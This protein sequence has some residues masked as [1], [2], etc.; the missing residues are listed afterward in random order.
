MK[1]IFIVMGVFCLAIT[2]I[3]AKGFEVSANGGLDFGKFETGLVLGLTGGTPL[4]GNILGEVEF[5]YYF[6]TVEDPG[7]PGMDFSGSAWNLNASALYTFK[8]DKSKIVPYAAFGLG[9]MSMTGK[10]KSDWGDWSDSQSKFNIAP[11]AGIKFPMND[12]SGIRA[13][14]RYIIILGVNGDVVRVTVGYYRTLN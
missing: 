1:K 4:S 7:I 3:S 8:L 10:V 5:Y 6:G 12:K 14:V 9:I 2:S 11:G 13:D